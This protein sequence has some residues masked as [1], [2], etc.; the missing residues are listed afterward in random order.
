MKFLQKVSAHY[1][2]VALDLASEVVRL[3]N[4]RHNGDVEEAKNTN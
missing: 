2:V 1:E 4:V 3:L